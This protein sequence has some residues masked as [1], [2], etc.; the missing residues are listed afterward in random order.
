MMIFDMCEF[1]SVYNVIMLRVFW[2]VVL[3]YHPRE[4][5]CKAPNFME[6]VGWWS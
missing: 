1:D 5:S 4:V 2:P 3:D 6:R